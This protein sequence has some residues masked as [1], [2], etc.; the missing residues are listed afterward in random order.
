M[1]A[2]RVSSNVLRSRLPRGGGW[3]GSARCVTAVLSLTLLAPALACGATRAVPAQASACC[4]AMNFAC[5]ERGGLVCCEHPRPQ[6]G[7]L[8]LASPVRTVTRSQP[9]GATVLLPAA[10]ILGASP[11]LSR[12]RA[13]FSAGYSPPPLALPFLLH[14]V[15]LI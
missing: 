9:E 13:G 4:R 8:A 6:D 7:G 11:A 14:S 10:S 15:L 1:R 12:A 3:S 2:K 5:H